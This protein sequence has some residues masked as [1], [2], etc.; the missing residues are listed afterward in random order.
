MKLRDDWGIWIDD[1][2][3]IAEKFI[4]NCTQRFKSMNNNARVLPNL[5]LSKLISDLDNNELI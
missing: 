3:M 4:S 5:G 1:H 2:K